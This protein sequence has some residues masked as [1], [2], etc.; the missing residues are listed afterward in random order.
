MKQINL[1]NE[2]N[3]RNIE[4]V[5]TFLGGNFRYLSI[6]M[7][8]TGLLLPLFAMSNVGKRTIQ[9]FAFPVSPLCY[10]PLFIGA[11]AYGKYYIPEMR[12]DAAE[13]RA[14]LMAF[15]IVNLATNNI[16]SS[17]RWRGSAGRCVAA[18]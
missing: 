11:Y 3:I 4:F 7:L 15:R 18:S 1:Q 17:I 2:I 8:T 5:D 16:P 14:F 12:N 13:V 10:A 6:M 9:R